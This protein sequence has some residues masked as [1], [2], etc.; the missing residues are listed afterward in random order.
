[1]III[2]GSILFFNANNCG[3]VAGT[4]GNECHRPKFNEFLCQLAVCLFFILLSR[5][6]NAVN[7]TLPP[8]IVIPEVL[9]SRPGNR[10]YPNV[11]ILYNYTNQNKLK[12]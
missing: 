1:M 2:F 5:M 12:A 4:H 7:F 3:N 11:C 9:G 8:L 10:E 6:Q